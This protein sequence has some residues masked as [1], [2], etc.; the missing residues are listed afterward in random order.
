MFTAAPMGC[1][2]FA[3]VWIDGDWWVSLTPLAAAVA[4]CP[5]WAAA[6]HPGGRPSGAVSGGEGLTAAVAQRLFGFVTDAAAEGRAMGVVPTFAARGSEDRRAACAA[7]AGRANDRLTRPRCALTY[8][9][10]DIF[11][12]LL[13]GE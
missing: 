5:C 10:R 2:V 8:G 13:A 7:I 6:V 1:E 9:L 11:A 4:G 12:P 3:P